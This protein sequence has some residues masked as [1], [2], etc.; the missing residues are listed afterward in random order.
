MLTFYEGRQPNVRRSGNC[1][2]HEDLRSAE[3][4]HVL[5]KLDLCLCLSWRLAFEYKVFYI[6]HLSNGT[7]GTLCKLPNLFSDLIKWYLCSICRERSVSHVYNL[8]DT[9]IS[10][11]IG[12]KQFNCKQKCYTCVCFA[13]SNEGMLISC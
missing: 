13:H 3:T 10:S 5:A 8:S 4:W 2:F 6:I 7:T 1:N 12:F 11:D 9:Q